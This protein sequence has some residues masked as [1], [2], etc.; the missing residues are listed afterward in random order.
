MNYRKNLDNRSKYCSISIQLFIVILIV[1]LLFITI[2]VGYA[3]VTLIDFTAEGRDSLVI[4]KWETA[5]ETSNVGFF[6]QRS[7]ERDR[8][9]LRVSEFIPTHGDVLLGGDYEYHDT[10]VNN[11]TTYWYKLESVD[12]SQNSSVHEPPRSATPRE[13]QTPTSTATPVTPTPTVSPATPTTNPTKTSTPSRTAT[14]VPTNTRIPAYPAPATATSFPVLPTPSLSVDSEIS[15]PGSE[16]SVI[17]GTATLIPLPA[18]AMEFPSANSSNQANLAE[19]ESAQ[20]V[21]KAENSQSNTLGF[22]RIVLFIGI[23]LFWLILGGLFVYSLRRL[24]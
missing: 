17:T 9:Y 22:Q 6:I 16:A 20:A 10:N 19:S 13:P 24:R 23:L 14:T 8:G 2:E 7:L 3:A 12:D 11:G 4:L 18:I 5:S 1:T 21:E 15:T